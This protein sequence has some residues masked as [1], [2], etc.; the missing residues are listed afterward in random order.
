MNW[1]KVLNII[2]LL[3]PKYYNRFTFFLLSLG[4]GLIAK[5]LWLDLINWIVSIF[6]KVTPYDFDIISGYD[7]L[8]GLLII[9]I[10][11]IYNT[12]HVK[13]NLSFNPD[14]QPA[15]K[16][17]NQL[18]FDSLTDLAI[19]IF[20]IL[21]DNEHTYLTFG[22]NSGMDVIEELRNDLTLWHKYREESI[23]PNNSKIKE[24]L[25]FNKELFDVE[26]QKRATEMV[27]HIDAFE[28]HLNNPEYDYTNYQ[29]PH[30]F[31]AL[32]KRYC[33]MKAIGTREFKRKVNW[34]TKKLK[35]INADEVY[36]F[37]SVVFAPTDAKDIDVVVIF[38]NEESS[39]EKYEK[40]DEIEHLTKA[41]FKTNLH[42][43]SFFKGNESDYLEFIEFNEFKFKGYG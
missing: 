4:G 36:F 22:P 9:V 3:I 26:F 1:D 18:K 39:L 43:T 33:F 14:Q 7:W 28:E 15:Y 32:V 6:N 25:L 40:L 27:A 2:K 10:G 31:K 37:G 12:I 41:R 20:P 34:I 21:K 38:K 24:L 11:L 35:K 16:E 8:L 30:E 19:A 29:F 42:L 13:M 23:R 5:P 17:Q